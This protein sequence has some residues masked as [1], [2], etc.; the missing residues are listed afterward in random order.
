MVDQEVQTGGNLINILK[1]DDDFAICLQ[2]HGKSNQDIGSISF[3]LCGRNNTKNGI[4]ILQEEVVDSINEK[5]EFDLEYHAM[6][7]SPKF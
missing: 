4:Y 2:Q 1:K 5:S 3:R 6:K 7:C